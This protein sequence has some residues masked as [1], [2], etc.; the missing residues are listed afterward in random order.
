MREDLL[1]A[2]LD[3]LDEYGLCRVEVRS[4]EVV[5]IYREKLEQQG[6]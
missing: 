3:G 6:S 1:I 2:K 4:P 5:R